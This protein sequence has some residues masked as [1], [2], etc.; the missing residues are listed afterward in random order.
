MSR[1]PTY[2]KL[3]DINLE[4]PPKEELIRLVKESTLRLIELS[5]K[6]RSISRYAAKDYVEGKKIFDIDAAAG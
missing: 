6:I 2:E 5:S 1:K 4:Q 3:G